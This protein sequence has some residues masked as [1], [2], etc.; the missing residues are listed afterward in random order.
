MF[1]FFIP[2]PESFTIYILEYLE[3]IIK[4]TQGFSHLDWMSFLF[5]NNVMS[6]F[7]GL[8]L[9]FLFGIYS[10]FG[11]II[12]GYM[13]GFVASMAV[14]SDGIL[15][16]WRIL[17]H[18]IFEL[19]AIFISLG[20]GLKF[21][22]FFFAKNKSESFKNFLWNSLR[23]FFLIVIPLLIVAAIIEGSLIFLSF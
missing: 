8:S 12:N 19:P 9:G 10:V 7:F 20:L 6:S 15:S 17:P 5:S 21:G 1:G 22:T 11:A 13:I 14:E 2:A 16:L 18:G 4:S 23:V 3:E